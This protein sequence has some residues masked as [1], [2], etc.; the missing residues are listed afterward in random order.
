MLE[1]KNYGVQLFELLDRVHYFQFDQHS[2]LS[3]IRNNV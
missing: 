3:V 1:L 2:L